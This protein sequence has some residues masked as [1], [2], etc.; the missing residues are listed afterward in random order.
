M[1][2]ALLTVSFRNRFS[3]SLIR[4]N[5]LRLLFE[6]QRRSPESL[7]PTGQ[8]LPV[9]L[10]TKMAVQ[11]VELASDLVHEK[12][13]SEHLRDHLPELL[14]IY[15]FLARTVRLDHSKRFDTS[16]RPATR[17][18]GWYPPEQRKRTPTSFVTA[19]QIS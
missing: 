19:F 5:T 14:T 12:A 7:W 16:I 10:H 9:G 15:N 11:S 17:I 13:L 8:L 6:P 1:H 4:A 18:L 3:N 2:Y